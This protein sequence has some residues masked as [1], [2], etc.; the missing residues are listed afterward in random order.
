[1]SP[2][3][4]AIVSKNIFY[5]MKSMHRYLLTDRL[6]DRNYHFKFSLNSSLGLRFY[7]FQI[8]II[9]RIDWSKIQKTNC[10]GLRLYPKF[11][12]VLPC[13]LSYDGCKIIQENQLSS[14]NNYSLSLRICQQKTM[15]I[16]R[17]FAR[18]SYCWSSYFRCMSYRSEVFFLTVFGFDQNLGALIKK[19][20]SLL[21]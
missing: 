2:I 16:N 21:A 11:W 13:S 19:Q 4:K 10:P 6:H 7:F 14:E 18:S 5:S 15:R 3:S 9:S 20:Y 1:M 8:W 12:S 17:R